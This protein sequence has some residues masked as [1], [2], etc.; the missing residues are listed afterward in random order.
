VP[1]TDHWWLEA[2]ECLID[3]QLKR[4]SNFNINAKHRCNTSRAAQINAEQTG[5]RPIQKMQGLNTTL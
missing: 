2:L 3:T 4:L 5:A 1:V